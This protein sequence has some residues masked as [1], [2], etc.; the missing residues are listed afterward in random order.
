MHE[1]HQQAECVVPPASSADASLYDQYSQALF[2]YAR[3]YTSTREDAEDISVE[4]FVAALEQDNLSALP[5]SERL[6]WLRRVAHNKIVDTYRKQARHPQIVLNEALENLLLD[7]D[8]QTPEMVALQHET[9]AQLYAV[10]QT[11]PIL[12][13]QLLRLRY[14]DG[15]P[16]SEIAV[17]LEKREDAVRKLCSRT[18]A[19]LRTIY[20]QHTLGGS[21]C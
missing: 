19:S 15:L 11:L 12:Q 18:L 6:A 5:A 14:G 20:Q 10:I 1:P 8:L 4:V 2:A 9:Y 7:D 13:Q 3:M 17:L 16:F 21:V